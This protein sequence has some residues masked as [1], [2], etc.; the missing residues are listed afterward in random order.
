MTTNCDHGECEVER[1][2]LMPVLLVHFLRL[3]SDASCVTVLYL[4]LAFPVS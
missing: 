1:Q 3:A 2:S 4:L